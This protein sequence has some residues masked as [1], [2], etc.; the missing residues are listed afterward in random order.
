MISLL[1]AATVA[2]QNSHNGALVNA[3]DDAI[4]VGLGSCGGK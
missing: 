4:L 1:I 2:A 3:T